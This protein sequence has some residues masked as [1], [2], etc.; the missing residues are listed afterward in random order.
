L[1]KNEY[2]ELYEGEASPR[3]YIKSFFVGMKQSQAP[4]PL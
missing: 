1:N 4:S 2:K 3:L